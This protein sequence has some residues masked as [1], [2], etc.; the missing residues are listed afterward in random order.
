MSGFARSGEACVLDADKVVEVSAMKRY[1]IVVIIMVEIIERIVLM[2]IEALNKYTH[3]ICN[4]SK[5]WWCC[6]SFCDCNPLLF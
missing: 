2:V 1:K 5:S 4:I 3:R 6:D